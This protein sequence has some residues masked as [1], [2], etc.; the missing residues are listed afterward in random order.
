MDPRSPQSGSPSHGGNPT[1]TGF[2]SQSSNNGRRGQS[3]NLTTGSAGSQIDNTDR[4]RM[5]IPGELRPAPLQCHI[6]NAG[7]PIIPLWES[8]IRAAIQ[9]KLNDYKIRR[10]NMSLYL[11]TFRNRTPTDEDLTIYIVAYQEDNDQWALFLDSVS[12]FLNGIG[13]QNLLVEIVDPRATNGLLTFPI[14]GNDLMSDEACRQCFP[15]LY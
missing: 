5:G 3:S 14:R 11:R 8:V 6:V 4:Y 1:L 7:N 9:T 10:Q 2:T 12:E 15:V 13:Y